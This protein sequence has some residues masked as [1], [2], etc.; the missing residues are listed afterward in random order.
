M[1][2]YNSQDWRNFIKLRQLHQTSSDFV[3]LRQTSPFFT[4]LT[5]PVFEIPLILQRILIAKTK[6]NSW[7]S[8]CLSYVR[9]RLYAVLI[10]EIF[11]QIILSSEGIQSSTI[12]RYDTPLPQ[13]SPNFTKLHQTSP[14]LDKLRQNFTKTSP[15]TIS[16]SWIPFK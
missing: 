4:N 11:Y 13:T 3:N 1:E 12:Y 14:N 7:Y 6:D 16:C 9:R 2:F 8:I 10:R 5:K 15:K